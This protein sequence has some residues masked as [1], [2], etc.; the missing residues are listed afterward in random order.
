M[1]L[2]H[3]LSH[4]DIGKIL[5]RTIKYDFRNVGKSMLQSY[6]TVS[7]YLTQNTIQ[8][9][10]ANA[11]KHIY[12]S[13]SSSISIRAELQEGK[14]HLETN[15]STRINSCMITSVDQLITTIRVTCQDGGPHLQMAGFPEVVKPTPM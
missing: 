13:D 7:S 1:G 10:P 15:K 12:S 2:I 9:H 6:Y 8:D 3:M 14:L 11:T 4:G 5:C